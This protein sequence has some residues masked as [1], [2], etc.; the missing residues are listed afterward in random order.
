MAYTIKPCGREDEGVGGDTPPLG[1]LLLPGISASACRTEDAVE[2]SD[3]HGAAPS[4]PSARARRR[5]VLF[6]LSLLITS[7]R[8]GTSTRLGLAVFKIFWA[9]LL[10][11]REREKL[12]ANLCQLSDRDL[13]DIGIARGDIE[14]SIANRSV[15]PR[16]DVSP[17]R[18]SGA[19]THGV[20]PV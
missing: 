9:A 4:G 15:D 5:P 6:R 20:P 16:A 13:R 2:R 8:A 7:W 14:Y 11:W 12:R 3:P 18:R 10:E 19:S 17:R 1:G